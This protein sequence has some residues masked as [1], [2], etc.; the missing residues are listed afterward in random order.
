MFCVTVDSYVGIKLFKILL[1]AVVLIPFV[2][3]KSFTAIGI[4]GNFK[5]KFGLSSNFLALTRALEKSS[6]I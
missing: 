4:P 3:N 5:S 2:Q 6:V 1:A